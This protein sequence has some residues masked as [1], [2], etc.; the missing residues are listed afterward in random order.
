MLTYVDSSVLIN[1]IVG[2]DPARK[3]RC[4]NI[5]G[6]QRRIFVATHYLML[7]VLPIPTKYR[8]QREL[9]FYQRFFSLITHWID[10]APLLPIAI[11]LACQYGLTGLDALHLVAAQTVN[12]EFV[13][14]ERPTKPLYMAYH[15]TL[16]V[17]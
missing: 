17:Y 9:H 11:T 3:M 5:F 7:E 13:S 16:S 6:D 10:E 15:N 8:L 14:A 12:A 2:K 1:A 4:L